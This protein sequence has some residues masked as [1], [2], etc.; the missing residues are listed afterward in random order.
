MPTVLE[1]ADCAIPA[2]LEGKSLV[3]LLMGKGDSRIREYLHGEH[4]TCYRYEQANHFLTDGNEKYIW[5]THD[6]S[7]QLFDINRDPGEQ[8]DL[9][10]EAA[11]SKNIGLWRSRLI[12]QLKGRP[13]GFTDG[14]ELIA[15]RP[16]DALMATSKEIV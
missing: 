9:A 10:A 16:H 5:F 12:E 14:K 1:L 8:R 7:E 2:S 13:E 3:P 6:G 15:G 11:F 4:A